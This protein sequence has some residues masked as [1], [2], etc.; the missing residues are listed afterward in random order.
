MSLRRTFQFA[1]AAVLVAVS[2][3][4]GSAAGAQE[5]PDYTAPPASEV[6]TNST[7]Q[8][9]RRISGA[10]ATEERQRLAITGS[11]FTQLMVIG[12]ILLAGGA[13]TLLVRRRNLA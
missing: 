10:E 3:S 2:L 7:P 12:S 5:N 13:A 6:V 9:A 4:L 8:Q 1:L 11:D